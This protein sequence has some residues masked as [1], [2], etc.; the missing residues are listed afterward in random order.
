VQASSSVAAGV[1]ISES[2][3]AG[4]SVSTGTAVNLVVSSG[5]PP[6]EVPS[7]VGDTQSAAT[8][9][10][11]SVGL[12]AGAITTQ[13]S[14][15]VAAG[16]VISQSPAA[17]ASV[18]TGSA[19]SLVISSGA[20]E[21]TV[22][23]VLGQTQAVAADT[24]AQVG[25]SVGTVT[26]QSSPT[27]PVGEVISQL[28]AAGADAAYQSSVNLVVSTGPLRGDI[29]LDGVVDKLDLALITAAL[30]TP[31]SGPDDPRDLNHDGLINILD[32]R[33]LVTLCTYAGCA[34]E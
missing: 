34:H 23:S 3:T 10:L 11:L 22:P 17:G 2:P 1:V 12:V 16:D 28:P 6:V 31:A 4:S 25:L 24:L 15:T 18:G 20:P 21:V 13:S 33:I 9:E 30:N 7:V 29:N 26:S 27:V 14:D 5:P 32:A 8:A 19:V